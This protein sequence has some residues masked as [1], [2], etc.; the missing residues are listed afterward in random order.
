MV[1][2]VFTVVSEGPHVPEEFLG[3]RV[4]LIPTPFGVF[5]A[6]GV[7]SF[8]KLGFKFYELTI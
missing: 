4:R 1:I 5:Q 6:M 8:G 7:I 2:I 3:T